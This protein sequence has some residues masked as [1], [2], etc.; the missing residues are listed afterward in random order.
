MNRRAAA[1]SIMLPNNFGENWVPDELVKAC[2]KCNGKFTLL[3]RR[4]S[5]LS[6]FHTQLIFSFSIIVDFVDAFMIINVAKI[7]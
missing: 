5:Q 7:E 1:V 2:E 3:N 4:V 6:F